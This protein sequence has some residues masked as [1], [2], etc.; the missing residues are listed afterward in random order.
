MILRLR[1][2]RSRRR[3][4]LLSRYNSSGR[5]VD[6]YVSEIAVG[7]FLNGVEVKR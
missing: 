1:I 3:A 2:R 7:R 4:R 5:A 6:A